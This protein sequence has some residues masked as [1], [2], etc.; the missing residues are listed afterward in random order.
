M[1][2]LAEHMANHNTPYSQGTIMGILTDMVTCIKEL[3]LDGKSVRIDNLAVFS[4]G[5]KNKKGCE[6]PTNYRASEYVDTVKMRALAIGELSKTQ[7]NLDASLKRS[8]LDASSKVTSD[9]EDEDDG[10]LPDAQE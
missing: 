3:L 2:G 7:L 4:V 10:P 9:V 1:T 6:D 5:I 8:S